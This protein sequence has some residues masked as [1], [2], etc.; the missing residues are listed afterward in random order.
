MFFESVAE[1][2]VI[3]L[4]LRPPFASPSFF[5]EDPPIPGTETV[6]S[7]TLFFVSDEG[8]DV[9]GFGSSSSSKTWRA[10]NINL[11]VQLLLF[12]NAA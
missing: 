7:G 12:G 11:I 4:T 9:S 8:T 2:R 5:A 3:R 1:V 10:N 6:V